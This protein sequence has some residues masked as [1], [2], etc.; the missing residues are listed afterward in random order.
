VLMALFFG[1]RVTC[2]Q[3]RKTI[4]P[5]PFVQLV[6]NMCL[7]RTVRDFAPPVLP[8]PLAGGGRRWWGGRRRWGGC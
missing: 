7:R 6:N 5:Q 8:G 2:Y 4:Y 3:M 1:K